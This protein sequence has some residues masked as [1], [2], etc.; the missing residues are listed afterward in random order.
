[1]MGIFSKNNPK[2]RIDMVADQTTKN[3]TY[4]VQRLKE[5]PLYDN[6][7][8]DTIIVLE[9]LQEA[10]RYVRFHYDFP[11]QYFGK[12]ELGE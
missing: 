5:F 7:L 10:K 6:D 4:A 11:L 2:W 9:H 12:P 8:Y 3:T 1:M